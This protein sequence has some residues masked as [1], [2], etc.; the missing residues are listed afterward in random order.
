M[1]LAGALGVAGEGSSFSLEHFEVENVID[2]GTKKDRAI[3][4]LVATIKRLFSL[5]VSPLFG[6][7]VDE[8]D[9]GRVS[10]NEFVYG[11]GEGDDVVVFV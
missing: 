3:G 4:S 11:I 5:F 7:V 1:S 9:G 2:I 10:G 6:I 8:K